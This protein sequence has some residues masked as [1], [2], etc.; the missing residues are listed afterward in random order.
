MVEASSRMTPSPL[1]CGCAKEV[2]AS[3]ARTTVHDVSHQL[4]LSSS[5]TTQTD[6]RLPTDFAPTQQYG[7][8][9]RQPI[10]HSL[11]P[12]VNAF[13]KSQD[14]RTPSIRRH[15][16]DTCSPASRILRQITNRSLKKHHRKHGIY[17][18]KKN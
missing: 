9:Y 2:G 10:R 18:K 14:L 15:P 5:V 4:S 16:P 7:P 1:C 17:K 13:D 8:A 6:L 3:P 12:R 11:R